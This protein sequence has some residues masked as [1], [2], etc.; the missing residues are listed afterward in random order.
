MAAARKEHFTVQR[1]ETNIVY[2]VA[3]D[4]PKTIRSVNLNDMPAPQY[5]LLHMHAETKTLYDVETDSP[6]I[7]WNTHQN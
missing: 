1:A 4:S 7:V 3:A 5:V 2:G 6:R